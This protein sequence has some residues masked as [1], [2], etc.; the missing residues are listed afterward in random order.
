[1]SWASDAVAALWKNLV[2]EERVV[3]LSEDVKEM[4][5]L[6]KELDKRM[7]KLETKWEVYKKLSQRKARRR[8][9]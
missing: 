3:A 1:M 7:L 4:A 8:L 9:L 2:L 6:L 5:H